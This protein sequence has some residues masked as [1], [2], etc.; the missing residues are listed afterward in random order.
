MPKRA[1][2]YSNICN[3]WR[4]ER[5]EIFLILWISFLYIF[6]MH[7]VSMFLVVIFFSSF[8][9]L[10][11]YFAGAAV[12]CAFSTFWR[13]GILVYFLLHYFFLFRCFLCTHILRELRH[14]ATQK[15]SERSEVSV[16][17]VR[18]HK[19][20]TWISHTI[21]FRLCNFHEIIFDQLYDVCWP[22]NRSRFFF[23]C[24]CDSDR[25]PLRVTSEV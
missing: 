24:L 17:S 8:F 7:S 4:S 9:L 12:V 21:F 11:T 20:Q 18:T 1:H 14:R 23:T 16:L 3:F 5:D 6:F 15:T 13:L 10:W 22:I 25:S 19:S 2:L